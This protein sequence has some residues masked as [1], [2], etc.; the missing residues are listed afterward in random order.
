[1]FSRAGNNQA[2]DAINFRNG[3]TFV[4]RK[5]VG[6][7]SP[8]LAFSRLMPTGFSPDF[9]K[10]IL[11]PIFLGTEFIFCMRRV[12]ASCKIWF[13]FNII[14]KKLG[15]MLSSNSGVR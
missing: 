2:G 14:R 3:I 1:M 13:L 7:P 10:E 6:R 15:I 9:F 5:S 11:L 8:R 4:S 12:H